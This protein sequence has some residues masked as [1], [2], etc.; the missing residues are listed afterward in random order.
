MGDTSSL[1]LSNAS[2]STVQ[3][4]VDEDDIPEHQSDH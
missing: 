3:R 4:K 1:V 2:V